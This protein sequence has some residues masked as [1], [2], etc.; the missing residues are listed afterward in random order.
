M[1]HK[2]YSQPSRL[3]R[4]F[5]YSHLP[6]HLQKVSQPFSELAEFIDV[7]T[8][9]DNAEA[10]MALRKLLEAKDCAGRAFLDDRCP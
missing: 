5:Q 6:E 7:N 9:N 3:S 10:S 4:Y 2:N 8:S 1:T